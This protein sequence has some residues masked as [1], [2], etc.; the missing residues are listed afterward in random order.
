MCGDR[1]SAGS[2]V[3]CSFVLRPTAF[4]DSQQM[5]LG[6][7]NRFHDHRGAS[8]SA[9][10]TCIGL[11]RWGP[12]HPMQLPYGTSLS[13]G[14][15]CTYDFH[16][17]C[18][19]GPRSVWRPSARASVPRCQ[20]LVSSVLGSP[21]QGPRSGFAPPVCWSCQSHPLWHSLCSCLVL[22][23]RSNALICI[24]TSNSFG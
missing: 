3:L 4:A 23:L 16:Q 19:R 14:R 10:P 7:A 18:P 9:S 13:L 11:Y 17:T 24:F 8:T 5:L 6:K 2:S 12:A 1:A 15:S 21:R 22:V 20:A